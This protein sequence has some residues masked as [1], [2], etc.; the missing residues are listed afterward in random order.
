MQ[1]PKYCPDAMHPLVGLTVLVALWMDDF[2]A[3]TA[4]SK[5]NRTSVFAAVETVLLV[6][7]TGS[8]VAAYSNLIAAGN[9]HGGQEG[10]LLRT[11]L[12]PATSTAAKRAFC[13]AWAR[14]LGIVLATTTGV[15]SGNVSRYAYICYMPCV[16]NRPGY[17]C[18][19]LHRITPAGPAPLCPTPS[20]RG[21]DLYATTPMA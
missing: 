8:L 15:R 17:C 11:S 19:Y 13:A 16:T 20:T 7:P 18:D 14:A 1:I 4:L 5:L 12:P 6:D 9:K 10:I 3:N 2:D 21:L